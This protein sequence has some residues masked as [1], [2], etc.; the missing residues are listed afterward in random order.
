MCVDED[1]IR[2]DRFLQVCPVVDSSGF[3]AL[4]C[5]R[6]NERD[7]RDHCIRACRSL[8]KSPLSTATFTKK[9]GQNLPASALLLF[10]PA[11]IVHLFRRRMRSWPSLRLTECPDGSCTI[12]ENGAV[13][14]DLK[15]MCQTECHVATVSPFPHHALCLLASTSLP[16]L[17]L[18]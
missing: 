12:A 1:R 4:R 13:G 8:W 10:C 17:F 3:C 6:C 16:L 18:V 7:R 9:G 5:A 15:R 14:S 11:P 2:L